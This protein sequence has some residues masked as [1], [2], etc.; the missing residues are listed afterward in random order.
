MGVKVCGHIQKGE[1]RPFKP[2]FI[3]VCFFFVVLL[4]AKPVADD[5]LLLIGE[6]EN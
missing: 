3:Q 1:K 2:C 5:N 6:Y 4:I